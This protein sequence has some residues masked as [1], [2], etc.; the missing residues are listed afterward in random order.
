[1]CILSFDTGV[2]GY[3]EPEVTSGWEV[4]WDT[5]A[6]KGSAGTTGQGVPAGGTA[7]QVL[8]KIDGTDYNTQ[9][10]ASGGGG[11]STTTT[12]ALGSSFTGD[13]GTFPIMHS[14]SV[15]SGQ[16]YK[17]TVQGLSSVQNTA[18]W[19]QFIID[20][21]SCTIIGGIFQHGLGTDPINS[22]VWTRVYSA[23]ATTHT[24]STGYNQTA[25][26]ASVFNLD[27]IINAN[28]TGTM[29]LKVTS[30]SAFDHVVSA[31]SLVTVTT[32]N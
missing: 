26:A 2:V 7:G 4:Y 20:G 31:N 23:S 24:I 1:M 22:I 19:K 3:K 27:I 18:A 9:W 17:L 6:V 32:V 11:G 16:R 13:S 8:S 21:V 15:T 30:N 29:N 25:T 10:V 14:W 12:T 5:L 28:A